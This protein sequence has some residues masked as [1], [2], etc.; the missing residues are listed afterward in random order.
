MK[1]TISIFL[2]LLALVFTSCGEKVKYGEPVEI[3]EKDKAAVDFITLYEN[4]ATGAD[5]DYTDYSFESEKRRQTKYYKIKPFIYGLMESRYEDDESFARYSISND[6]FAKLVDMFFVTE[7]PALEMERKADYENVFNSY[8]VDKNS[9]EQGITLVPQYKIYYENGDIDYCFKRQSDKTAVGSV[10]YTINISTAADV[11]P[12]INSLYKDGD[13][14]Y[15]LKKVEGGKT[16]SEEKAVVEISTAQQLV[17]MSKDYEQNGHR[18][19]DYV[20][21]LT[22]DI[23]MTGITDFYPIGRNRGNGGD[24]RYDYV[25]GFCSVFDGQGYT[26]RNLTLDSSVPAGE[27]DS[28]YIALFDTVAPGGVVKNL[29]VE[30]I[31]I[32]IG[33]GVETHYTCAGFAV[34]ISGQV[35]NCSVQGTINNPKG[36]GGGFVNT[37]EGYNGT[38]I[39]DCTADVYITGSW[40]MGGF[41]V[42]CAQSYSQKEEMF[43]LVNCSSFGSITA[44]RYKG[45]LS[46]YD[47]GEFG[48]FADKVYGGTFEKC[49]VQTPLI[50][51]DISKYIGAFVANTEGDPIT[52]EQAKYIDCTYSPSAVGDRYLIGMIRWKN[53]K[54]DY[55]DAQFSPLEK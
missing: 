43:K 23:D 30:N 21:V 2:L 4:Y 29:N 54:G 18:Y 41:A 48:G 8:N 26:I 34:Y 7:R 45:M 17:D 33:M 6:D 16:N 10:T 50:I 47:V 12:V 27:Y 49:H 38:L 9:E 39:K 15:K 28:H 32:D 14:V 53:T 46:Y 19:K 20:Y 51:N 5:Y 11:P 25:K 37:V 22:N 42:N 3:T 31:N 36:G 40:C 35:L 44:G 13:T 52:G 55:G 24:R 1:K